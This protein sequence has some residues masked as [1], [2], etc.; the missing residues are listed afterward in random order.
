LDAD[1]YR[2]GFGWA[3]S[4]I[5]TAVFTLQDNAN[6]LSGSAT[7]WTESPEKAW[8]DEEIVQQAVARLPW[9][10]NVTLLFS[11]LLGLQVY[12]PPER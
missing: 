8:P 12:A 10:H 11:T 7:D 5:A 3:S 1:G 6:K 9:G 4:T 2:C